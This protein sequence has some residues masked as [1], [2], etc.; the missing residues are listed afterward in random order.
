[1]CRHLLSMEESNMGNSCGQSSETQAIRKGEED[2]Q[3]KFAIAFI[4][5]LIKI[6]GFAVK[7]SRNVVGIA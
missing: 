4:A 6:K 5:N 3:V 1:M 2:T 7:N